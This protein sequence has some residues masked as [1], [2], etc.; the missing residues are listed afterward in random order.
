VSALVFFYNCAGSEY[1]ENDKI[2]EGTLDKNVARKYAF[3]D[4][5]IA[6]TRRRK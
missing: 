1:I 3:Y 6:E 2:C 4:R 5:I